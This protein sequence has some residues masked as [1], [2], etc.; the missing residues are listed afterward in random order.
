MC[1]KTE[2][3]YNYLYRKY[4]KAIIGKKE[5]AIELGIF[6]STL[7]LYIS[8]GMGILEY[9]KL[10]ETKYSK[11]IWTLHSLA[12]FLTDTIKTH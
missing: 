1:G 6:P 8:R 3:I 9:R 11:V 7:D 5:M 2:E 10:G 4:K 12:Y